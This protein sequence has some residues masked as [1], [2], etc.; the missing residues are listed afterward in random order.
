MLLSN[1]VNTGDFGGVKLSKSVGLANGD[2]LSLLSSC[3]TGV[4]ADLNRTSPSI[5][6]HRSQPSVKSLGEP[7]QRGLRLS[8]VTSK[9]SGLALGREVEAW[10]LKERQESWVRDVSNCVRLEGR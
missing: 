7:R 6:L 1:Y 9:A 4:K 8:G 3:L 2:G 5:L 10:L